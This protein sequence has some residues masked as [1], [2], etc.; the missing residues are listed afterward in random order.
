MPIVI[1]LLRG[2]N[3]GGHNLI[4]M[5][6]LR[7]LYESVGYTGAQT[8]LQS[9][10]VVFRTAKTDLAK[11]SRQIEEAIEGQYGF[12]PAVV[13][14]TAAEMQNLVALNPFAGRAGIEPKRLAVFFL[15]AAP[16]AAARA[17]LSAVECA[18]EE[19]HFTGERELWVYFTNGMA[20]PKLSPPLI[21]RTLKVQA[22]A[23]NWNTVCKLAALAV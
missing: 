23:R 14:R 20:R 7:K 12:R 21:E 9:G 4:R 18:P 10:N 1:S 15:S 11:L 2:I 16:E 19:L 3:V 17:R 22:T 6:D 8:L 13:H 5:E